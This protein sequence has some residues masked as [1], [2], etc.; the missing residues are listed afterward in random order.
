MVLA[1]QLVLITGEAFFYA[2][3]GQSSQIELVLFHGVRKTK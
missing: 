1:N 2:E 3:I